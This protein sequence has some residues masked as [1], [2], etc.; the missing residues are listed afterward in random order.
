MVI[1]PPRTFPLEGTAAIYSASSDGFTIL[2]EADVQRI[3]PG[4]RFIGGPAWELPIG[5]PFRTTAGEPGVVVTE[6]VAHAFEVGRSELSR[7]ERRARARAARRAG[8]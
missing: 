6:E 7:R 2:E 4:E 5:T 1:D 3:A 8:R